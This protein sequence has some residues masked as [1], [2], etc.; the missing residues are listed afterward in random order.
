MISK[1]I[2]GQEKPVSNSGGESTV[3]TSNPNLL[4]NPWFTVNQRSGAS[5]TGVVYGVDRWKGLSSV[6]TITP[7]S[8]GI[9]ISR[10][11]GDYWVLQQL[12]ETPPANSVL[13]VSIKHENGISAFTFTNGFDNTSQHDNDV[14]VWMWSYGS[15]YAVYI[16]IIGSSLQVN[17]VKLE[18]GSTSTL[19]LDTVPDYTTERSKCR[20]YLK[21]YRIDDSDTRFM[22][23]WIQSTSYFMMMM[24]FSDVPFRD[25]TYTKKISGSF[26]VKIPGGSTYNISNLVL[27]DAR[28]EF[29]NVRGE[30]ATFASSDV[31]KLA[32]LSGTN[33]YIEFDDEL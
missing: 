31:G 19:H 15:S 28:T 18:I 4:D 1:M 7:N 33:A 3:L 17:A 12:I 21:R 26:Q 2:N 14:Y 20:R 30:G 27:N 16:G 9:A 5:Y 11:S 23:G 29:A 24:D 25:N 10:P 8:S 6:T 22:T 13:T 32:V